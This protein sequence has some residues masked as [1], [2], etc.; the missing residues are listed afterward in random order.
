MMNWDD[1]SKRWQSGGFKMTERSWDCGCDSDNTGRLCDLK[2][3]VP[4]FV[5]EKTGEILHIFQGWVYR[6]SRRRGNNIIYHF[7]QGPGVITVTCDDV[8]VIWNFSIF[9]SLLVKSHELFWTGQSSGRFICLPLTFCS[10]ALSLDGSGIF[11]KPQL[12]I[13]FRNSSFEGSNGVQD[14]QTF[15]V[16]IVSHIIYRAVLF[17]RVRGG[18]KAL[19]KILVYAELKTRDQRWTGGWG[20]GKRSIKNHSFVV[21]YND[22]YEFSVAGGDAKWEH[23]VQ[24]MTLSASGVI[25]RLNKIKRLINANNFGRQRMRRAINVDA[26]VSKKNNIVKMLSD[27]GQEYREFSN[28]TRFRFRFGGL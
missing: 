3:D 9:N 26:K 10:S 16:K 27:E 18:K 20:T 6:T 8:G 13:L 28:E 21:R 2:S 11:I 19:W 22:I 5:L 14:G 4:H 24:N 17:W 7:E 25:D 12:N 23:K 1:F 15:I